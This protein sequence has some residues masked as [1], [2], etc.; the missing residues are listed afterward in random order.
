LRYVERER[1]DLDM[2][3]LHQL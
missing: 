2:V 1:L 3:R